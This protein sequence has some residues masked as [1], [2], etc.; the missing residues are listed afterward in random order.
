[1]LQSQLLNQK[2]AK[3]APQCIKD[4][5]FGYIRRYETQTA[6]P[7]DI[8]YLCILYYLMKDRFIKHGN[9]IDIQ[10]SDSSVNLQDIACPNSTMKSKNQ[11]PC[12]V[13]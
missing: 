9:L 10:S 12:F 4:L 5:I 11:T 2:K 7:N 1:M 6:V 8:C 13:L 3:R